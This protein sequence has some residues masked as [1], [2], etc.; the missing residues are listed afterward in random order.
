MKTSHNTNH[1]KVFQKYM[2]EKL[3][4]TVIVIMLALIALSIRLY[5]LVDQNNEEYTKKVLTQHATYDSRVIPYRRGDIVDRNGT[6]LATSEKVYNLIIDPKTIYSKEENYLNPTIDALVQ[7]FGYDRAE[8]ANAIAEKKTSA[9]L[10]YERRL[11]YEKKEEFE[12]LKDQINKANR[13]SGSPNRVYGVWFEDEYKRIYP[14]NSLACNVIGFSGSDSS[15]GTGG[16]EQFYNSQL[17]GTNG[18]EYG[19]LNDESNMEK[20]IKQAENGNTIVS[21]IDVNIQNMVEKRIAE[22]EQELGSR[23]RTA[24]LVMDPNNGEILAMATDL[25]YDLNDPRNLEAYYTQAEID[26]MDENEQAE[27]W[28]KMWR[29]FCV[30]DTFEPGSPSKIFTVSAGMEESLFN[31]NTHFFCD[32]YQEVGGHTIKCTGYSKGGH[33]DM[34][35]EETLIVSCN[36]AM[37]Q[38]GAMEGKEI[39]TKYMSMFNFGAKTG[40]DLPGEADA[41][42]LVYTAETMGPTDLATNSFGQSYNCTMIQMAAA[43][44]SVINGGSYY[45][46]HVAKQILNEQGA[47]VRKIEPVLVRETVSE[48]TSEFIRK[49]LLRTVNEG[50]GK[51]AAVPGYDIGGKTGTAEKLPRKQGNYVVSFCGFAPAD[52]PQVL[53]YVVIDEPDTDDQA[54]SSYASGLFAKIMGDILPY[55]NI[56]PNQDLPDISDEVQN[57]LPQQEGITDNRQDENNGTTNGETESAPEETKV[58]ETDEYIAPGE[59]N[60]LPGSLPDGDGSAPQASTTE[61][62]STVE[63]TAESSSQSTEETSSE[64]SSI[65][66]TQPLEHTSEETEE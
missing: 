25:T 7:C 4:I 46:P 58:Y 16:I 6:Y 44:S 55:M 50:T 19:Y 54:H 31:A 28:N 45:E 37:M 11:S 36:D 40:I 18:R 27:A 1:K 33:K 14:Y 24:V 61:G 29:N 22:Y 20:N 48:S 65:T 56:F 15:A 41:S 38:M 34:T 62:E 8:L 13:E 42:T 63:S 52:D 17:V 60:G 49:A 23:K 53:V 2:Q 66:E 3:A 10:R 51:A 9:Y 12:A 5:Y 39:F 26:A 59:D 30:S 47:V 21:T 57:Q 43:F 35:L 32:G 64:A